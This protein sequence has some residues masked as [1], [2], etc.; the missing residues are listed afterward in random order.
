MWEL[1]QFLNWMF[2][3]IEIGGYE[4]KVNNRPTLVIMYKT[5]LHIGYV[6]R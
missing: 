1:S 5:D 4:K 6:I 3:I 2:L